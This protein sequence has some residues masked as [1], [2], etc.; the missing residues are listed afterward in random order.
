A[1][2]ELRAF[3]ERIGSTQPPASAPQ[4]KL[5]EADNMID[6]L[7]QFLQR[8]PTPQSPAPAS[9]APVAGA[10]KPSAPVDATLVGSAVCTGCH[11]KTVELFSHTIKGRLGTTPNKINV[12]R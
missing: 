3:A 8:S 9:K 6:A 5:A 2:A 4:L 1:Y 10:V 11:S 7:R 12:Q